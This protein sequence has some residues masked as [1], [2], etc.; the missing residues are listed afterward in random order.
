MSWQCERQQKWNKNVFKHA[1][2]DFETTVSHSASRAFNC[3]RDSPRWCE[4][5]LSIFAEISRIFSL[6]RRS[7]RT[8]KD[9]WNSSTQWLHA[10]WKTVT[11]RMRFGFINRCQFRERILHSSVTDIRSDVNE[12]RFERHL[13]IFF[14]FVCSAFMRT[15][16]HSFEKYFEYYLN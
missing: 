15:L 12:K 2:T 13:K 9:L 3:A 6:A 4:M 11:S 8:C 16:R 10:W 7:N 1:H 14:L 5:P